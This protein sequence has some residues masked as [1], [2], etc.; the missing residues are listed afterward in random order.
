MRWFGKATILV[1]DLLLSRMCSCT[2]RKTAQETY[3]IWLGR[4][5]P[6]TLLSK[7]FGTW[8]SAHLME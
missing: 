7:T 3:R 1:H 6:Q 2:T 8:K 4:A 5:L